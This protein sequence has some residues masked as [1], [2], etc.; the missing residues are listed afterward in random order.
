MGGRWVGVSCRE[1]G[2]MDGKSWGNRWVG[3][4][5]P[6]VAGRKLAS[7]RDRWGTASH[8]VWAG[9]GKSR[10]GGWGDDGGVGLVCGKPQWGTLQIISEFPNQSKT[11]WDLQNGSVSD[12][13]CSSQAKFSSV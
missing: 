11:I 6:G 8:G 5:F 10:G 3:G 7:H 9:G 13:E 12:L 1:V 4:E 2:Q